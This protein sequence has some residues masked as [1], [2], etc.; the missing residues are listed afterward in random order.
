LCGRFTSKRSPGGLDGVRD[1]NLCISGAG[2]QSTFGASLHA[3][4]VEIAA[5]YCF[6][7]AN[8]PF[9]DGNKRTAMMA[10]LFICG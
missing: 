5:A 1:E 4:I 3:E 9:L 8:H 2:S 7:F 10:A 6:I